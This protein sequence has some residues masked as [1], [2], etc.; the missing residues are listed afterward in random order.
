MFICV[1]LGLCNVKPLSRNILF[2][3]HCKSHNFPKL[4]V[5]RKLASTK[6][7]IEVLFRIIAL[8]AM[9]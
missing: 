7:L 9:G 4:L 6:I 3:Y 5:V 1:K 2:H 8:I